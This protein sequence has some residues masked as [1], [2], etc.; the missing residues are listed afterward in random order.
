MHD[1][2]DLTEKNSVHVANEY[3]IESRDSL[4]QQCYVLKTNISLLKLK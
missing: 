2:E 1:F 3:H 4:W